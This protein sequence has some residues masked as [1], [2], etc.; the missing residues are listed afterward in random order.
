MITL[1]RDFDASRN[2]F[3]LRATDQNLDPLS[4]SLS[5]RLLIVYWSACKHCTYW[6]KSSLTVLL[7]Y[8]QVELIIF[9]VNISHT[10]T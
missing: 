10:Q 2:I 5:F 6:M 8:S 7:S 3:S 1:K 9:F 4:D